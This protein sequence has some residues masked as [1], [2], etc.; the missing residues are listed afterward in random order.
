VVTFEISFISRVC[1]NIYSKARWNNMFLLR[2][3]QY[4]WKRYSD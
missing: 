4:A 2:T 1:Q 3:K